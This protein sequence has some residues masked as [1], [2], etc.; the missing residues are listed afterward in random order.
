VFLLD[1]MVEETIRESI[2]RTPTGSYLALEPALSRDIIAAVTK[3]V[4]PGRRNAVILTS[5]EIRRFVRRLIESENPNLPVLSFQE[6]TPETKLQP[7][8]RIKVG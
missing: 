8:G 5:A 6:I 3:T 1:P 2:Q 7:L 4:G